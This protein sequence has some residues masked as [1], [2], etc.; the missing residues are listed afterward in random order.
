VRGF[1]GEEAFSAMRD[2]IKEIFNKGDIPEV[3]RLMDKHFGMNNY[4]LLHLFKDEQRK[5]LHQV[6]LSTLEGIEISFRKIRDENYPIMTFL[7]SLQMPL[8]RPLLMVV[9][10]LVNS[11]LKKIF[12]GEDLDIE[13]LEGLI[14]E[15]RRWSLDI[16]KGTIG[17]VAASWIN[18]LME[19]LAQKRE[20]ISLFEK[21]E[22]A[23]KLLQSFSIEL[24]LWRAQNACFS[25]GKGQFKE[26]NERLEKG[27]DSARPWVETFRQLCSHLHVN[28][29]QDSGVRNGTN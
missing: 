5:V 22:K 3:I 1:M 27:D 25:I 29:R 13:R 16:D 4:S 8:P 20:E 18:A 2:E 19:R 12:V 9:E 28:V 6:L 24:D 26:M 14:S 23:L 7:Q 11:D 21:V 10:Y 17:F 15:A